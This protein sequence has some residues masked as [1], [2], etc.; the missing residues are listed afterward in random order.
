M[1]GSSRY[2]DE[3]FFAFF[4]ILWFFLFAKND[5]HL[6]SKQTEMKL[7]RVGLGV[8]GIAA[9]VPQPTEAQNANRP[10]IILIMT[11]QQRGDAMGC[12]SGGV[13]ITPN[14]DALARDGVLFTSAYSSVP[15][16]TPA[17]AGLLTGCSPWQHG[18]IGYG[19]QAETYPCEMPSMLKEAGYAALAVG[20]M[21]YYPQQN[22]HG[23]DVVLFD[24]SGRRT[25]PF[26][27]SD[28]RKWFLSQHFG[29]NPD[30]TGLSWNGHEGRAY[31]CRR[32]HP[33]RWTADR[34]VEMIEGV[35]TRRNRSF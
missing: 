21:H 16:S 18:M 24:E 32:V 11:D 30:A 15:S 1:S 8:V 34:A 6:W 5:L 27:M 22:T 31:T 29:T 33:T 2:K 13:V 4:K 14:I 3:T 20:K 28:Y 10:N 35:T 23:Y 17:R 9:L 25:S 12:T 19:N 7:S 26:F